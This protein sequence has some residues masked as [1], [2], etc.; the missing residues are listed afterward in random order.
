MAAALRSIMQE[1]RDLMARLDSLGREV[2][3]GW[4]GRAQTRFLQ[5][6]RAQPGVAQAAAAW[7]ETQTRRL[8]TT[9]V[10]EWETVW[11]KVWTPDP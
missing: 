4:E 2:E 6:Y 8:E 9:T 7:L 11:E 10:T 5:G 3:V 1:T